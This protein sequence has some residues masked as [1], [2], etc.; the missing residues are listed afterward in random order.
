M[1]KITSGFLMGQL[2]MSRA[3]R[4]EDY[5]RK[6]LSMIKKKHQYKPNDQSWGLERDPHCT[7]VP[8]IDINVNKNDGG[9]DFSKEFFSPES[10]VLECSR[11]FG[12]I[13]LSIIKASYFEN[14]EFRVLKLEVYNPYINYL[15]KY[16][17]AKYF[18]NSP[19]PIYNPHVT[20]AYLRKDCNIDYAEIINRRYK[21]KMPE[22]N[23]RITSLKY[24]DPNIILTMDLEEIG[25]EKNNICLFNRHAMRTI[26]D[27]SSND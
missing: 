4:F 7:I 6:I 5:W 11:I 25:N 21:R 2:D 17:N 10:I 12:P 13:D 18:T 26:V 22:M 20:I 1:V 9:E 16:F 15:N 14:P 27:R 23:A 8:C 24:R 19:F 3:N